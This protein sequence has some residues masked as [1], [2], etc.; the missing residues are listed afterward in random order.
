MS[1]ILCNLWHSFNLVMIQQ[2]LLLERCID[3]M[4]KQYLDSGNF[5]PMIYIW[6]LAPIS[7]NLAITIV[8]S[9]LPLQFTWKNRHQSY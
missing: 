9:A 8:N 1:K 6:Y 7:L 5:F 3:N 4:S 2:I